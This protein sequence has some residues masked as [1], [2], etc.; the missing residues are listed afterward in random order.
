MMLREPF[1]AE[2]GLTNLG[3]AIL[4]NLVSELG[5]RGLDARSHLINKA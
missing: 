1:P 4:E 5:L 3:F 2:L